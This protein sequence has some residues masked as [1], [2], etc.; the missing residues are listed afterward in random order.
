MNEK[1]DKLNM[2]QGFLAH[3]EKLRETAFSVPEGY[4]TQLQQDIQ[5]RIAEEQLRKQVPLSG[6]TVPAGY[7]ESLSGRIQEAARSENQAARKDSIIRRLFQ[8]ATR[9]Y[10]AAAIVLIFSVL[11]IKDKLAEPQASLSHISDQELI[12]YL[13]FYGGTGDAV[14]ISENLS[15]QQSSNDLM[16]DL[17][18]DEIE[19]YLENTW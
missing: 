9:R 3:D 18:A 17:T 2:N 19:W 14:V 12:Q 8:P 7:F 6:M 5:T 15:F 1:D 10:V 16:S 13:Q 4:F 11:L